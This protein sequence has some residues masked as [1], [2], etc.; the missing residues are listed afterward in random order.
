[1]IN[2]FSS[3]FFEFVVALLLFREVVNEPRTLFKSIVLTK[4]ISW[5]LSQ[6]LIITLIFIGT[7]LLV[8]TYVGSEN[9]VRIATLIS[10]IAVIVIEFPLLSRRL[11]AMEVSGSIKR[12]PPS[13]QILSMIVIS[14]LLA[15]LFLVS[16]F[17]ISV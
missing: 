4:L 12:I 14:Q 17:P 16:V 11:E 7:A 3:A 9:N 8:T 1:M 15:F 13:S 2:F 10:V 6:F 5:P